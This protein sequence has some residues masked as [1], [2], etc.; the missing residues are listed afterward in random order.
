MNGGRHRIDEMIKV[1]CTRC[2]KTTTHRDKW[3]P[4]SIDI[5]KFNNDKKTFL[6]PSPCNYTNH[7]QQIDYI[8]YI[9]R[10]FAIGPCSLKKSALT[11]TKETII[12]KI[13]LSETIPQMAFERILSNKTKLKHIDEELEFLKYK[14]FL[15]DENHRN[16]TD[17][18]LKFIKKNVF[19]VAHVEKVLEHFNKKIKKKLNQSKTKLF[20]EKKRLKKIKNH[21]RPQPNRGYAYANTVETGL[22]LTYL[23]S[24]T[25]TG[26]YLYMK[27][28][29]KKNTTINNVAISSL[30]T[31]IL[32]SLFFNS[33]LKKC[34]LHWNNLMDYNDKQNNLRARILNEQK[35][36]TELESK[37]KE[38]SALENKYRPENFRR[39]LFTNKEKS[40][41]VIITTAT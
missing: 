39:M 14:Y 15:D 10:D 34:N 36:T 35:K 33:F 11:E 5:D 17:L 8:K 41:D 30:C 12:Y 1:T 21:P 40:G 31:H 27:S 13:R 18:T 28:Q 29:N 38:I 7:I 6:C 3:N 4:S 2:K 9:L 25:S 23:L 20:N 24:F 26:I 16:I 19:P 37:L 32:G 22:L